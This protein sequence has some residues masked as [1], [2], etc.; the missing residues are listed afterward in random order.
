MPPC[1]FFLFLFHT[2]QFV[3]ACLLVCLAGSVSGMVATLRGSGVSRAREWAEETLPPLRESYRVL[4]HSHD[5][6]NQKCVITAMTW[7]FDIQVSSEEQGA[8]HVGV[9]ARSATAGGEQHLGDLVYRQCRI[10]PTP[11]W[12][13]HKTM[14]YSGFF[15]SLKTAFILIMWEDTIKLFSIC[16]S[17]IYIFFTP[18]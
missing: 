9:S 10:H 11:E 17:N 14:D 8:P 5:C 7:E 2:R 13:W 4:R 15:G 1:P 16:L 18:K 12:N 6:G 3:P